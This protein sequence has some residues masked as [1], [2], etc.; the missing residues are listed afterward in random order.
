MCFQ[1]K[2]L[3]I[4]I[5][6]SELL[7]L[8]IL[9]H[10]PL[11][12]VLKMYIMDSNVSQATIKVQILSKPTSCKKDPTW[13]DF[14]STNFWIKLATLNAHRSRDWLRLANIFLGWTL[15]SLIIWRQVIFDPYRR[16]TTSTWPK[17]RPKRWRCAAC[18]RSC[19]P[20][21][22]FVSSEGSNESKCRLNNGNKFVQLYSHTRSDR[23]LSVVLL[24]RCH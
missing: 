4:L 11:A 2:S 18:Q 19:W 10:E 22:K 12:A 16:R 8:D 7:E 24:Q 1:I 5:I 13:S 3:K 21:K 9:I 6:Q 17:I 14:N 15:I 23:H 20:A